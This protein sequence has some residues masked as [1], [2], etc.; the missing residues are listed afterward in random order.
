MGGG[1]FLNDIF[2]LTQQTEDTQTHTH[3]AERGIDI[4]THRHT[5]ELHT[6]FCEAQLPHGHQ[7]M[8]T[9]VCS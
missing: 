6:S 4:Q 3:V 9:K 7:G 2:G 8:G 1:V 5:P